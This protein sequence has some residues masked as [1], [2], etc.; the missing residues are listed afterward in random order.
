LNEKLSWQKDIFLNDDIYACM[1]VSAVSVRISDLNADQAK[2]Y[3]SFSIKKIISNYLLLP[4]IVW[5]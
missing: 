5:L 4:E 3:A 2:N 1:R